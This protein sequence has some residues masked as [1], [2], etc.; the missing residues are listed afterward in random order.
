MNSGMYSALSGNMNMMEKLNVVANN[1]ANLN[2]I[3]FKKDRISFEKVMDAVNNPSA[4]VNDAPVQPEVRVNTDYSAGSV[5]RS[6]NTLDVAIDGD[7]FFMVNTPEGRA[8]TRQG[9]FRIDSTG[10]LTTVDGFEVLSRG[11]GPITITGGK[12]GINTQGEISIDDQVVGTI[13]V[14]DFPKPYQLQKKGNALFVPTDPQATAQ[15]STKSKIMQGHLE[16]SNVNAVQEMLQILESGRNFES[17]QRVVR[18]YDEMA[19]K[20][21]E[22]GRL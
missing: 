2:T 3:G 4:G 7:G 21:I 20:A 19:G 9:S 17:C 13:G 1:L 18:T 10:K 11:G 15:Q 14:V 6:G 12:V 5:T 16:S 22:Y 8:Y